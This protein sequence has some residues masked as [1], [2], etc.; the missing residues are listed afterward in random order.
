MDIFLHAS[1]LYIE[2]TDGMFFPAGQATS[3]DILLHS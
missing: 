3:I 2:M 1:L